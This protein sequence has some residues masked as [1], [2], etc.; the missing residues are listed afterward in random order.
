MDIDS[1]L[2][3]LAALSQRTRL[4]TFRLLVR[5]QP[6]GLPAGDI[7]RRMDVPQN[8]MSTHLAGLARAGLVVSERQSRS[9]VYR[10]DLDRLRSLTLFLVKDCCGGEAEL[11]ESLIAELVPCC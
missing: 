5:H 4:D 7:A 6:D 2:S 8:T 11:C 10:A 1:A 3:A 9:I